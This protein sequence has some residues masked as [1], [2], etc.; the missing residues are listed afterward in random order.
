MDFHN[1]SNKHKI[2]ILGALLSSITLVVVAIMGVRGSYLEGVGAIQLEMDATE[3]AKTKLTIAAKMPTA[4]ATIT[5]IPS[6]TPTVTF[7]PS[8]TFTSIPTATP[9]TTPSV[10]PTLTPTD[11]ATPTP[12]LTHTPTPIPTYT[13]TPEVS[14][15]VEDAV[16]RANLMLKAILMGKKQDWSN[17]DD[18]FC[19]ERAKSELDEFRERLQENYELPLE[20]V[21]YISQRD[22]NATL[23]TDERTLKTRWKFTQRERW[24]YISKDGKKSEEEWLFT[25]YLKTSTDKLAIQYCID[26]YIIG[27]LKK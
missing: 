26:Y 14:A 11:T 15:Q 6:H 16:I 20:D 9:T 19:G 13:P 10:T 3:T 22:G 27:H 4:T 2:K 1:L 8:P 23:V 18:F 25:Y 21:K 7:T 24:T 12:T 17:L 5:A